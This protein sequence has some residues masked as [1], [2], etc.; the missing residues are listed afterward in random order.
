M[1]T[2][3]QFVV[4][5]AILSLIDRTSSFSMGA[6]DSACAQMTPGHSHPP[7][8]DT[9]PANLT[10]T[11]NIVLPGEMIGIELTTGDASRFKGFIIQARS[12]KQKDRQVKGLII[13]KIMTLRTIQGITES[14]LI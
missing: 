8:T 1:V 9:P 2:F 6:P 13:C 12:V 4:T 7:Q 11:R 5:V 14:N 3:S 10:L